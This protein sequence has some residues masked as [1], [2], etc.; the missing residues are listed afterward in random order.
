MEAL[1]LLFFPLTIFVAYKFIV[2]NINQ[3]DKIEDKK[4]S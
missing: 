3:L 2:L 1:F 4:D